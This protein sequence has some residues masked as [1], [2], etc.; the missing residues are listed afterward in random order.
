MPEGV[1]RHII[2]TGLVA[3]LL[4]SEP[5]TLPLSPGFGVVK[6]VFI[7][8]GRISRSSSRNFTPLTGF[9]PKNNRQCSA[10][11]N[12]CF[13]NATSRLTVAGLGE[14][15][16]RRLQSNFIK[17]QNILNRMPGKKELIRESEAETFADEF[18]NEV[19]Q[20]N[21]SVSL[22]DRNR[23]DR[24]TRGLPHSGQEGVQRFLDSAD[25]FA[26]RVEE[27]VSAAD[28]GEFVEHDEIESGG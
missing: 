20:R 7:C 9:L 28:R 10:M 27:G 12:I 24:N 5:E 13:S 17:A 25:W 15:Q 19:R 4:K 26:R 1:P 11:L 2:E 14:P 16:A 21:G 18:E 22:P 3:S 8:A 23:I 6:N